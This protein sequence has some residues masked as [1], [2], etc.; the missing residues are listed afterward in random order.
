MAPLEAVRRAQLEVDLDFE[1]LLRARWLPLLFGLLGIEE[2][3]ETDMRT[4]RL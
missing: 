2:S 4:A 1:Q 3:G